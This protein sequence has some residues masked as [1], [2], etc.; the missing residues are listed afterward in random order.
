MSVITTRFSEAGPS[1][2]LVKA[3]ILNRYFVKGAEINAKG[4]KC[5]KM[6]LFH[7][8]ATFEVCRPNLLALGS[9]RERCTTSKLV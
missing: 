9:R 4:V 2:L 3:R 5:F 6:L 1:R 8:F 7:L